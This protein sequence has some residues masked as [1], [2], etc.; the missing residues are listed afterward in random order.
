LPQSL[1][2]NAGI[3]GYGRFLLQTIRLLEASS[4]AESVIQC[5][6]AGYALE[7]PQGRSRSW[8]DNS[9]KEFSPE[10]GKWLQPPQD[11]SSA[12][13]VIGIRGIES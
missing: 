11:L 13:V 5:P 10:H 8:E 9:I 1:Q 12:V 4:S 7:K 2:A 3:L 6:R